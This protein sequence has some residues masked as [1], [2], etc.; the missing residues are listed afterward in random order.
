[1]EF[2]LIDIFFTLIIG[3]IIGAIGMILW[4]GWGEKWWKLEEEERW[5]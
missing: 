1:M 5:V 2:T 4:L 3:I